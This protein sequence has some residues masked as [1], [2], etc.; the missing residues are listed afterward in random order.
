M[1]LSIISLREK[2]LMQE[3]VALLTLLR[4]WAKK[5]AI[6]VVSISSAVGLPTTIN[7]KL[8]PDFC[9]ENPIIY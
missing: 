4:V 6:H 3:T 8:F 2:H 1:R 9:Y 5:P 7:E